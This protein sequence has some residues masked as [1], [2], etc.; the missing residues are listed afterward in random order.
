MASAAALEEEP[1]RG[2]NIRTGRPATPVIYA[3]DEQ[4]AVGAAKVLRQCAS[5]ALLLIGAGVTLLEAL[6]AEEAL[7][8]EG[9]RVCVI[10][11][12]TVKPLDAQ[13]IGDQLSRVAGRLLVVEDH[14]PEGGL[15]EAVARSLAGKIRAARFLAVNRV[16]RSGPP[17]GCR[18]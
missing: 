13:T 17:E 10:D 3:N 6:K 11:P 4:F 8:S 15:G 5:D 18:M 14:Y 1:S 16:P 9:I 12:F 7:R 2:R